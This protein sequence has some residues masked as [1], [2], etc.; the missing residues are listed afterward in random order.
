MREGQR[1]S[2]T[3]RTMMDSARIAPILLPMVTG[4][5]QDVNVLESMH[6]RSGDTVSLRYMATHTCTHVIRN[7]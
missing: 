4:M 7:K 3:M 6:L 1:E 2:S 5:C